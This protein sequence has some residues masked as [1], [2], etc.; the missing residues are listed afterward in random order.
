MGKLKGIVRKLKGR[1]GKLKGIVRKLKGRVGK[2]K[3]KTG[4]SYLYFLGSLSFPLAS[5]FYKV[6]YYLLNRTSSS[7]L[8]KISICVVINALCNFLS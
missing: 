8:N 6:D 5:L 7:L 1:V 4:L 2:L 3:G